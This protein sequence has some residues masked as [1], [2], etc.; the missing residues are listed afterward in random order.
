MSFVGRRRSLLAQPNP[1]NYRAR[2][3]AYLAAMSVQP[4]LREAL[5][6]NR[7]IA[8]LEDNNLIQYFDRLYGFALHD[9]QAYRLDM[10]NPGS[11]TLVKVNSPT[12]VPYQGFK[13]D[14]ISMHLTATYKPTGSTQY[15]ANTATLGCWSMAD[16][17]ETSY[18]VCIGGNANVIGAVRP[19]N[20]TSMGAR[21]NSSATDSLSGSDGTGMFA[22]LRDGASS[23]YNYRN[24]TRSVQKTTASGGRPSLALNVLRVTNGATYSSGLVCCIFVGALPGDSAYGT[25]CDLVTTYLV[26]IGAWTNPVDLDPPPSGANYFTSATAYPDDGAITLRTTKVIRNLRPPTS[27]AEDSSTYTGFP[28]TDAANNLSFSTSTWSGNKWWFGWHPRSNTGWNK[29]SNPIAPR[30]QTSGGLECRCEFTTQAKANAAFKVQAMYACGALQAAYEAVATAAGFTV[31]TDILAHATLAAAPGTYFTS[32]P[33]LSGSPYKVMVDKIWLPAKKLTEQ[34]A[35][36]K[37]VIIDYEVQSAQTGAEAYTQLADLIDTIHGYGYQ[38][39]V[40]PNALNGNTQA[41]TGLNDTNYLWQLH[42]KADAILLMLWS[43]SVEGSV[44]A[45]WTNQVNMLKGPAGDKPVDYSKLGIDFELGIS[46]G[47][48][49]ESDAET[50]YSIIQSHSLPYLFFWANGA[51]LGGDK[52]RRTNRKI[53]RASFGVYPA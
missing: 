24:K 12:W 9:E 50:V 47:G 19:R 44:S 28:I 27:D 11:D 32:D 46:P 7:F 35:T 33:T 34:A 52:T 30:I 23:T 20:G 6:I 43:G 8:G 49:S 3:R 51:T 17:S 13:G 15:Q 18:D 45:S 5:T 29:R 42:A 48:T 40:Y 1:I 14:A 26:G 2:T 31:A 21:S 10:L 4:S 16:K 38:V 36:V 53:C 39:L 25:F 37:G 22:F 41:Y